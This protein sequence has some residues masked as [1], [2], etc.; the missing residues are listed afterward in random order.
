MDHFLATYTLILAIVLQYFY[1]HKGR[2]Y[3]EGKAERIET[4][5]PFEMFYLWVRIIQLP[6]ILF[7]LYGHILIAFTPNTIV[8]LVGWGISV[9]CSAFFIHSK[10]VLGRNYSPCYDSFAPFSIT[11]TGI[12]RLIR[13]PIYSM[14]IANFIGMFLFTGSWIVLL[15]TIVLATFYIRSALNEERKLAAVFPEYVAYM[16]RTSR[17]VPFV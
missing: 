8:S 1:N 4:S 3:S 6:A 2:K 9:M 17:F 11:Q 5:K 7:A 14:N 13:H 15:N 12:Y 10:L 16:Q